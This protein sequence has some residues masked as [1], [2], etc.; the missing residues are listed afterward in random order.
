[1]KTSDYEIQ[2]RDQTSVSNYITEF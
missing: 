1:M 2:S